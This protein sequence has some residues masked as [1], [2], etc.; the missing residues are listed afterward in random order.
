MVDQRRSSKRVTYL[1]RDLTEA[2]ILDKRKNPESR[3]L[4]GAI[5]VSKYTDILKIQQ[6]IPYHHYRVGSLL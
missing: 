3:I 2:A 5:L 1:S 6:Y 4:V